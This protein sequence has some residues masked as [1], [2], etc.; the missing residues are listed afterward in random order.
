VP[1][2]LFGGA[3]GRP[4]LSSAWREPT[5]E[6]V[7]SRLGF[8]VQSAL[9]CLLLDLGEHPRASR[10][11]DLW[12]PWRPR[13]SYP[14]EGESQIAQRQPSAL[15][16]QPRKLIGG[17]AGALEPAVRSLPSEHLIATIE[18]VDDAPA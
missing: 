17:T 4:A 15:D 18:Q 13:R 10:I 9:L 6:R 8:G 2:A 12:R 5:D 1:E 14:A 3:S 16:D 11:R 7:Q